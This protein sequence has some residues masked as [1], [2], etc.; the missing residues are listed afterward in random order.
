M[1]TKEV[2][3]RNKYQKLVLK[4]HQTL[5]QISLCNYINW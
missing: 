3:P 5:S 4:F 2:P 1:N